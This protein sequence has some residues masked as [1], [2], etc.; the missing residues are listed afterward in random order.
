MVF[1]YKKLPTTGRIK[2]IIK[3]N[4]NS[5]RLK[6]LYINEI[7]SKDSK[8][9]LYSWWFN[10]STIAL[11]LMKKENPS[12]KVYT[13]AHRW[14]LYFEQN[15]YNYLP[16]RIQTCKHLDLLY[17][18]SKQGIL[19]CKNKWKI[20]KYNNLKLSRLGVKPQK[21]LELSSTKKIIVSCSNIIPIKR[22]EKI[23]KSISLIKTNDIKWV[24]F[25]SGLMSKKVEKMASKL[26][27]KKVAFE[28]MGY[29]E[30]N[31]L[32]KWYK[33]NNPSLFINLSLSEG[34]PVSIMEAM[35][36]GIPCIASSVGGCDELVTDSV[37]FPV[38]VNASSE[39]VSLIIDKFFMLPE[40]E[41]KR[42]RK[43]A[44]NHII[45]NFNSTK[46]YTKFCESMISD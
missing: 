4:A 41:K 46:N 3:S 39:D 42:L 36:F 38:S 35:S 37:G 23:I 45:E 33:E 11:S 25:G 9:Y 18:A 12:L 1:F 14:D 43:R 26:L 6:N 17:S 29:F 22:V 15:I 20:S 28:F 34:I 7:D 40:S 21:F 19:Y 13:R 8:V 16:F 2:T 10:D 44:Y 30:N 24:H 31:L 5:F 32:L 27:N